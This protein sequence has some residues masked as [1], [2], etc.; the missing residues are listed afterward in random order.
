MRSD[1]VIKFVRVG[2]PLFEYPV[3]VAERIP[4][5]EGC[6]AQADCLA[7]AG[8]HI[9]RVVG[10]GLGPDLRWIYCLTVSVR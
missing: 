6:K 9:Q 5:L 3:E 4:I 7:P 10:R 8:R 2:D 1:P